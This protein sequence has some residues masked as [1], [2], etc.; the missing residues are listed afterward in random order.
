MR[1]TRHARNE[2]R[3]YGV[4]AE[5]AERVAK[6]PVD[7][8]LDSKGNARLT[9]V[10]EDGRTVVVVLAQDQPELAITIFVKD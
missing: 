8:S 9:G 3:L 7:R 10:S 1:F 5:D 4:S 6:R 2:M